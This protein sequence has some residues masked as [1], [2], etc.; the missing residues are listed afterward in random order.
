MIRLG[1]VNVRTTK[2]EESVAFYRDVLGL[3]PGPASTRPESSD[4]VWMSDSNGNPCVH[5]Q[6]SSS[7]A[8]SEGA[9]VHHFAFDCDHADEWRRKL[10]SLGIHHQE[11][12]FPDARM[13]QFNLRD[14][15]GVL[16]EL[17][18]GSRRA[19]P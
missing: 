4:H 7:A 3:T 18:F 15:N 11:H 19:R 1:H 10:G 5:L 9:V 17:T 6:R 16:V 8:L 14:P 13:T 12:E 2:L